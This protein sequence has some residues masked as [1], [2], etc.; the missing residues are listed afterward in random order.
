MNKN[1]LILFAVI[2]SI[3]II[4]GCTQNQ[5][6]NL[7][8][9]DKIKI[10]FIG[11]LSGEAS[12][13]GQTMHNSIQLALS[14]T[15]NENIQVIYE[16]TQ[17]DSTKAI[18][19]VNKLIE[20]DKVNYIIGGEGSSPI[21]SILPIINNKNILVVSPTATASSLTGEDYFFRTITS[22]NA[23]SDKA[24]D[25][26]YKNLNKQDIVIIYLNQESTFSIRN[27]IKNK[28]N[29]LGI[30]VLAEESY[31]MDE[32]NFRSILTKIMSKKPEVVFCISYAKDLGLI[33]KQ[34]GELNLRDEVDI[35]VPVEIV[36]D[37]EVIKIAGEF[38]D[39][40]YYIFPKEATNEEALEFKYNYK[41][42]YG[43]DPGMFGAEAYDAFNLLFEKIE[44]C[45]DDVEC[46]RTELIK[47]Q[48]YIG[49]SGI[50]SFDKNGDVQKP[51]LVKRIIN[52]NYVLVAT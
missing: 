48:D 37:P 43:E 42:E 14:K 11:P 34:L 15:N 24:V 21:Q 13:F 39:G 28:L 44:I 46:V 26:V 40:V 29:E 36:E 18:N 22:D 19:A 32:T 20:I 38:A 47:T 25:F 35:I 45:H 33:L 23:I 17:I 5:T 12:S 8:K 3:L 7:I 31:S 27:K 50:L 52:Q 16:D 10:G 9:E 51:W 41:I 2:V 49:A 30:D 4:A 6:G 1:K